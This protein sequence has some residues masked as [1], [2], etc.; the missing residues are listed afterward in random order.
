MRRRDSNGVLIKVYFPA[1]NKVESVKFLFSGNAEKFFKLFFFT[2]FN[3]IIT[4]TI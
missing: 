3:R 1:L 4:S 2:D